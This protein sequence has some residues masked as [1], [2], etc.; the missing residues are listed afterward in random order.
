MAQLASFDREIWC[1]ACELIRAHG[2]EAPRRAGELTER[3]LAGKDLNDA[4]LWM[5]VVE[6]AELLLAEPEDGEW[7]H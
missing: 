5:M 7:C 6:A 1:T 3:A 4:L 2:R